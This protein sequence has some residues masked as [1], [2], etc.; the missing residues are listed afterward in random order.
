VIVLCRLP[1]LTLP[2]TVPLPELEAEPP[3]VAEEALECAEDTDE[4]P[5][6]ADEAVDE[7]RTVSR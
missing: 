1:L 3:D 6:V 4:E 5:D 7:S 2:F